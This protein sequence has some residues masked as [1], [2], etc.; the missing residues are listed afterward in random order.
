MNS[1]VFDPSISNA[2]ARSDMYAFMQAGIPVGYLVTGA[3]IP[4]MPFLSDIF[5]DLPNRIEGLATHPCYHKTCDTLSWKEG[6]LQD[7]NFDFDLY[8]Q[9]SKAAMYAVYSL[10]MDPSFHSHRNS[11]R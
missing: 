10:S 8:L 6:Q 3:E 2:V 11:S 4:W 7:P 5:T 1:F 9:M